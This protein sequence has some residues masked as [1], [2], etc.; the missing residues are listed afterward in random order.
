[1]HNDTLPRHEMLPR[2]HSFDLN[3]TFHD[4]SW[5]DSPR[6][7]LWSKREAEAGEYFGATIG[8]GGRG[9]ELASIMWLSS[10]R[11]NEEASFHAQFRSHGIPELAATAAYA[12][13]TTPSWVI[14]P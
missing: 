4:Q 13:G 5:M 2:N 9:C 8:E 6:W 14:V 1:M 7:A 12:R 3:H 10:S 11:R